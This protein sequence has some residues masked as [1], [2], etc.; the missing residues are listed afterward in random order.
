M[1]PPFALDCAPPFLVIRFDDIHRTLGWSIAR[2]GFQYL[3]EI[4]WLEVRDADLSPD[5]DPVA[6][7]KE[8]LASKGLAEA[9]AFMTARDVRRHHLARSQVGDIAA[10]CVT[11]VGLSNAERVGTRRHGAARR[12]GTINTLVHLSRPLSTG[13]FVEAVSIVA[14]ART[15]AILESRGRP[16]EA[17]AT[18]TGTDCIVVAAPEGGRPQTCAGLHTDVGEAIGACVYEATSEGTRVW[19]ADVALSNIA[20]AH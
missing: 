9:A 14:Q 19:R 7:L 6:F 5:V 16:D 10:T 13:A 4:A 1:K 8:R 15:A 18:G 11:T 20:E 3:R 12:V 2:P 17:A